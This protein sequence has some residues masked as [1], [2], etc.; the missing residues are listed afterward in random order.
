MKI[1]KKIAEKILLEDDETETGGIAFVGETLADFIDDVYM[2]YNLDL[3][4]YNAALVK[5]G[6]KRISAQQIEK[7]KQSKK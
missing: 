1:T 2:A 3:A 4:Y 6:I 7:A 5:C